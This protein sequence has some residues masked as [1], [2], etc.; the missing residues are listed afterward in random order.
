MVIQYLEK[1]GFITRGEI[2]ELCK[3]DPMRAYRLLKRLE[4][5][6]KIRRVAGSTK[7]TKYGLS[8]K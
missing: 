3:I 4:K 5:A 1:H 8:S 2:A 6:G 7:G